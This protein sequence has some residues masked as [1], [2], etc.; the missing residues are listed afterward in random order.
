MTKKKGR[1]TNIEKIIK[2]NMGIGRRMSE[3]QEAEQ[4]EDI[5]DSSI[6]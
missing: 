5:V 4:D 2:G 1:K 6:G 3:T